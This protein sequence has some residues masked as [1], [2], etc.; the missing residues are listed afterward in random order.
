MPFWSNNDDQSQCADAYNQVN[1][2]PHKAALS[3]ELIAAAASYE[4]AKAYENHE[5]ANGEAPS[6]QK[7]KELAAAA[8]GAFVDRTVETKGLDEFDAMRAKRQA[9][10]Q[11][12]QQ[13]DTSYGDNTQYD[14]QY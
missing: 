9:K 14:N 1:Q 10:E 12:Y 11:A 4:A 2:A 3:H 5:A 8:I 6:H 7:A 13:I